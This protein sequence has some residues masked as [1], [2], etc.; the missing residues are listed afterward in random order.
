MKATM[1]VETMSNTHVP[2]TL[3]LG[4]TADPIMTV[5]QNTAAVV[6]RVTFSRPVI[7]RMPRATG[8]VIQAG[9][10]PAKRHRPRKAR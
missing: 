4:N 3:R 1:K 9:L 7:E 5:P 8:L 6:T 10:Q 2:P